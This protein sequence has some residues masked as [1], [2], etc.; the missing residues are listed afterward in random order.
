MDDDGNPWVVTPPTRADLLADDLWAREK[1]GFE[2]KAILSAGIT[3]S[4]Q[5]MTAVLRRKGDG[6]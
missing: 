5:Y 4:G 6:R 3:A 1:R 2:V